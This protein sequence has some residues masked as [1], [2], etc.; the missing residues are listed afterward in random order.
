MTTDGAGAVTSANISGAIWET[1]PS[2]DPTGS[3]VFNAF[4][5]VQN[6]GTEQ[7]YNTDGRPLEFDELKSLTFTHAALLADVPVIDVGGTLYREFQLDINEKSSSPYMSLDDFHVYTTNDQFLLGFPFP[8][9]TGPGEAKLIYDLG[10]D[11]YILMDYRWN[12]GSGKRDYRVL[13]PTADF[14]GKELTYVVLYTKH[15]NEATTDDGFEEWGVAIYPTEPNTRVTIQTSAS[16]TGDLIYAGGTVDLT[17]TETNTGTAPLDNVSVTVNDGSTDIATLTAP[18]DSGDAG[19]DGIL[20]LGETWTWTVSGVVVNSQ[21]TFTVTGYGEDNGTPITY[22]DYPDEQAQI[23]VYTISP[24]TMVGISTSASVVQAGGTV[25]L[26]IT[27]QNTGDDDLT[28]AYVHVDN[29][30]GDLSAPPDSGDDGDGILE[31]GETWSWTVSGVVVSAY[32]TFTATGHGTDSLGGDVTY[33]AYPDEQDTVNVDVVSPN[34]TVTIDASAYLIYAGDTVDLT[35]TEENT[36][37]VDLTGAYVHVDNGVGDLS[38]PPDS[39]DDGDGILEVGETWSWT[40]S[41]VVV[42][43]NTTFTATG[44]GT[45]SLGGDVTYPA[46]EYEQDT[47]DVDVISP[48]TTVTISTSVDLI[49]AGETVDLTITEE[50]TGSEDLTGAYVHVDN[51]I[52][53][54]SAPPDSGDDGDGI[55]EVGETWSWTVSGVTVN[56]DTTFTAIGHGTDSLGGDVT[57][58]AF[59]NERDTV[60]VDTI[61]PDTQV[62]IVPDVYETIAGGNV[63][64]TITEYNS[65]DDPLDSVHVV[66][67]DGSTDIADLDDTDASWNSDGNLDAVLDPGETWSW[68]YQVTI[69]TNTTFT[70]TGHGIDSLGNDVTYDLYPDEQDAVSVRVSGDFTRTWGFWK[71]H[72]FLVDWMFDP[73]GNNIPDID[74]GDW[75][76][77]GGLING[78]CSYMGLMWSEQNWNSDY[79]GREKIDAARIHTAHQALAAIM[80]SYMP[81]GAALPV[82][83]AEIRDILESNNIKDIR[84]LGSL[85]AAFN[86]SG[87]EV[88]FDPSVPP[89]GKVS[90][91]IADPQ[92]GREAG[93]LCEPQWDTA[94][95][96]KGKGNNK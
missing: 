62:S 16:G 40:V 25:N 52:G 78:V 38:A 85:L 5:R 55:L 88:A 7:G 56:S 46:Y 24:D 91:N 79:T 21:T 15:G 59:E 64:L 81:N 41:G 37:G 30:I 35:V 83:L 44:H 65:G 26:T 92:G 82:S 33:P 31:V 58:P 9:G 74:L 63:I 39:G 14:V 10:N 12:T 32:T 6:N 53:D 66:V 28:G 77:G 54:L 19:G 76:N 86:E 75:P 22:P 50:N 60:D 8:D 1:L 48:N 36:G 90:G 43:A 34:T 70:V 45:D 69:S 89:T 3:G 87:E 17:V 4:F 20:G 84:D 29:G 67:N 73:E 61:S 71:T 93:Y 13:V 2:S 27:E 72:L 51:G 96:S 23:T 95:T 47:V 68:T 11:N 42:N 94:S 18:P 49:Y 80:N 57:Y